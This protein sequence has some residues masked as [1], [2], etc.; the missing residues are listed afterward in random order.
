MAVGMWHDLFGIEPH[1]PVKASEGQVTEL[2]RSWKR[3]CA[4]PELARHPALP[5]GGLRH[6]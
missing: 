4:E 1:R 3:H 2:K 6:V 5:V